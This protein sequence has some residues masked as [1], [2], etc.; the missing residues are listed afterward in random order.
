LDISGKEA[1][2]GLCCGSRSG[3]HGAGEVIDRRVGGRFFSAQTGILRF[4]SVIQSLSSESPFWLSRQDVTYIAKSE[5][6]KAIF[7]AKKTIFGA[8]KAICGARIPTGHCLLRV[9]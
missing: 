7:G 9:K 5:P 2:E 1:G 4:V 8:K 6:K 3:Q